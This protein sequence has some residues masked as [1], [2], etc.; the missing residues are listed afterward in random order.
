MSDCRARVWPITLETR[1]LPFY[2]QPCTQRALWGPQVSGG[3][4][5]AGR[6]TRV[7]GVQAP[8]ASSSWGPGPPAPA[9]SP[10]LVSL[11]FT[12][13]PLTS[14]PDSA[15]WK[16]LHISPEARR[17]S[18]STFPPAAPLTAR[19]L[20]LSQSETLTLWPRREHAHCAQPTPGSRRACAVGR[21][22]CRFMTSGP[23]LLGNWE[24]AWGVIF[25]LL[26]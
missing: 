9:R 17:T 26:W 21:S 3:R 15:L 11:A 5:S 8:R 25:F 4:K 13:A 22:S 19:R 10:V 14:V 20:P 7:A 16:S 12:P 24:S 18:Y 23:R 6:G 1:Q 2:T